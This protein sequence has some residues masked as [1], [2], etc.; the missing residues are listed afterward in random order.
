MKPEQLEL[1]RLR[2]ELAKVQAERDI[3][4]KAAA[5]FAK[6]SLCNTALSRSIE[7]FGRRHG[8]ARCLMSRAAD[9][10]SGSVDR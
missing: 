1:A 10:M 6:E 7:E 9:S 4:K 2:K 3:L 8:C 5:Y